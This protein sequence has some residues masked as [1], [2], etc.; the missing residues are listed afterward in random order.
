MIIG[1]TGKNA[2]GKGEVAKFL[3]SRGFQYHSL[4]DV[5]RDE[6]KRKHLTPTRDH[7]T[8]V[9]NELREKYGPSILAE[10][11]L[12]SLAESQNYI[13]DSFRNPAEVEAF[14]QRPDFV[15]WAI[16]AKPATRLKRIQA[17]ARE[18]DP[19]TLKHFIAVEKREAHNADPNKQSIDACVKM[20]PMKI[21]NDGTLDR[22][23]K[24]LTQRLKTVLT[25][26]KRPS[27]DSYFM[28]IARH[29]ASRGNC[30]KRKVAALLVKDGRII[31]TGYNGTPRNTRNCFEGGCPRCNAVGPSGQNLGDCYCSHG[32]E[33]AIVQAAYHGISIKASTL[34]TTFSPCLLCTKMIINAGVVEVVYN[35]DYPLAGPA[36][37]LLKEASVKIRKVTL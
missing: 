13:V 22:L 9:G 37:A 33:N 34:Y 6:L 15:L 2:S 28:H 30:L 18:S 25:H 14:R 35:Q 29:V 17:R 16:T 4:S 19:V 26:V 23:H 1:L 10:R 7:L 3:E 27:W 36:Q 20:A 8:R 31:S 32:E 12:K 5:L 21:S 24:Q 11:I